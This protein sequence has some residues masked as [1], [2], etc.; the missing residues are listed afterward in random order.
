MKYELSTLYKLKRKDIKKA[1]EVL[2]RAFS[3]DPIIHYIFP[4]EEAKQ[5]Q[6]PHYYRF[7]LSYGLKFGEIYAPSPEI[8][9]LAVWYQSDKYKMNLLKQLRAGGIRLLV[10]LSK[11]TINRIMPLDRFSVEMHH[12]YGDFKFWYLSPMCVD[13][14]YQGKGYGSLLIRSMLKRIDMEKLAS[15]LETQSPV[16]VEIYKRFGYE[17]VGKETIP[18]TEIPYWI[19]VRQPKITE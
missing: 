12:K 19:M 3:S 15:L 6:L 11:E 17:V 1:I 2:D 10:K 5:N 16:N 8:E 4:S 14:K 18:D 13:P 7:L 9:G